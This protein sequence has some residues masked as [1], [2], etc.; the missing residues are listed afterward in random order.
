MDNIYK[1][2]VDFSCRNFYHSS[3][4]RKRTIPKTKTWY[5][6]MS[7]TRGVNHY[8]WKGGWKRTSAGYII[9]HKPEHP[10]SRKS[11]GFIAEHRLVMEKKIG[12]YLLPQE[13]VHHINHD[14]GDNRKENLEL[15]PSRGHHLRHHLPHGP[16]PNRKDINSLSQRQCGR[17]M[18]IYPLTPTH[19]YRAKHEI[20]GF[21]YVCKQ[22]IYKKRHA[23][24]LQNSTS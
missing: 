11:D 24:R 6:A 13:T 1:H 15:F 2:I 8:K 16:N 12:R 20:N 22:C 3:M 4:I 7:R 9:I 17:C 23:Q 10:F 18:N 21:E 14:K 5:E 19:F